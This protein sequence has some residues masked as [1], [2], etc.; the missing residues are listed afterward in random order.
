LATDA[1]GKLIES[2]TTNEILEIV[3]KYV[4]AEDPAEKAYPKIRNGAMFITEEGKLDVE[5]VKAQVKWY[6]DRGFVDASANPDEFI[7]TSFIAPLGQ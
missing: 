4:Y 1:D 7:D 6:Q 5:D 3:H 2:D